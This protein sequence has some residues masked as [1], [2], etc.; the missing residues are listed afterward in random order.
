[1]ARESW[2]ASKGFPVIHIP[3]FN[4]LQVHE[5]ARTVPGVYAISLRR[6]LDLGSRRDHIHGN[7]CRFRLDNRGVFINC[8][9]RADKLSQGVVASVPLHVA[10]ES[11]IFEKMIEKND[12]LRKIPRRRHLK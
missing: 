12:V 7:L 4:D 2:P 10:G 1:M 5:R 6:P 11:P 8:H 3:A 9:R